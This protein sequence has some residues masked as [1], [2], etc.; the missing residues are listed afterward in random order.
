[1]CIKR[2]LS[3]TKLI[4]LPILTIRAIITKYQSTKDVTNLPGRG[5]VSI[6]F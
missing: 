2:L 3:I 5:S 1:M 6:L 4:V